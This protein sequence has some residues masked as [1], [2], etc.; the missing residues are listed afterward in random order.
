MREAPAEERGWRRPPALAALLV[1]LLTV[2]ALWPA[3]TAYRLPVDNDQGYYLMVAR[4][5]AEGRGLIEDAV[6]HHLRREPALPRPAHDYWM[7]L[8][9]LLLAPAAAL[10]DYPHS[11]TPSVLWTALAAGLCALLVGRTLGDPALGFAAGVAVVLHPHVRTYGVTADSSVL[12]AALLTGALLLYEDVAGR[13]ERRG[14]AL[15]LGGVLGLLA[16]TRA[17][18]FAVLAGTSALLLPLSWRLGLPLPTRKQA[19][20]I[21]AGAAALALPWS[22]RCLWTFGTPWTGAG[23]RVPFLT[24]PRQLYAF[25][26]LPDA[27]SYLEFVLAAPGARAVEKVRA[28]GAVLGAYLM[29]AGSAGGAAT[30]V[31][32]HGLLLRRRLAAG[33]AALCFALALALAYGV[34][35]TG[36][37]YHLRTCVPLVP[38]VCWCAAAVVADLAR[39]VGTVWGARAG[40]AIPVA[41]AGAAA[42]GLGW[43]ALRPPP[44]QGSV[45]RLARVY[46]HTERLLQGAGYAQGRPLLCLQPILAS[47]ATRRPAVMAPVGGLDA[48][49]AAAAF[50]RA[51]YLL[52]KDYRPA[53]DV[54]PRLEALFSGAATDPRFEPVASYEGVRLF[55]VVGSP[56]PR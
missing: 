12:Q 53:L 26:P 8:P 21:L 45:E 40:R 14:H 55:R 35:A 46:A 5:L 10:A 50:Y 54:A 51:E 2:P 4:N 36:L 32:G 33:A 42:V 43:S 49:A 28:V 19:G 1:A 15:A 56:E 7:P 3:M 11:A 47:Y 52:L 6:W 38:V 30:I 17:D 44:H 20:W 37:T 39:R 25:G 41:L 29:V 48:V 34:I 22:A 24:E 23:A 16:L 18:A 31:L 9:A 13:P 27:A